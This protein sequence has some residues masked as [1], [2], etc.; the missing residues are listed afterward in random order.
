MKEYLVE[1][2]CEDCGYGWAV[3]LYHVCE[4]M[5]EPDH[6]DCSD[7]CN[8]DELLFNPNYHSRERLDTLLRCAKCESLNTEKQAEW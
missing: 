6:T 1:S 5:N 2:V 4:R 7:E 8:P 3:V